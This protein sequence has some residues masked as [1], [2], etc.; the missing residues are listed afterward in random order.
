MSQLGK[1]HNIQFQLN[2][3]TGSSFSGT[4]SKAQLEFAKLGKEIQSLKE[5]LKK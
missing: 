3:Q 4:F 5:A 1:V 2:A